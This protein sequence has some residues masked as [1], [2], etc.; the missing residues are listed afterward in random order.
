M[1]ASAIDIVA[2]ISPPEQRL[3]QAGFAGADPVHGVVEIRLYILYSR[4]DDQEALAT[5]W[6]A[7]RQYIPLCNGIGDFWSKELDL[8]CSVRFIL[9]IMLYKR[10]A[11]KANGTLLR[12]EGPSGSGLSHP[13]SA[14]HDMPRGRYYG[15]S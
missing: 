11:K 10:P 2:G 13:M 3:S 7:M 14:L 4:Q 5:D 9:R 12:N 15:S 8:K 1:P 6:V